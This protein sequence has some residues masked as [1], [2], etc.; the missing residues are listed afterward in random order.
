MWLRTL[1]GR[2][3]KFNRANVNHALEPISVSVPRNMV[4]DHHV[5]GRLFS[6]V[7]NEN[8]KLGPVSEATHNLLA[9]RSTA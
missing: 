1:K 3:D 9:A 4:V 5:L 6:S 8:A 2:I 7:A